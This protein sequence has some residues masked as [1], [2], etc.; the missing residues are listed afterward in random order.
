[1]VR[2]HLSEFLSKAQS[3]MHGLT[4]YAKLL[5]SNRHKTLLFHCGLAGIDLM[6]CTYLY[7]LETQSGIPCTSPCPGIHHKQ[8]GGNNRGCPRPK[9][10]LLFKCSETCEIK[11]PLS[12][13]GLFRWAT[14]PP[15]C[16]HSDTRGR[17]LVNCPV[18]S[19]AGAG[20]W[21]NAKRSRGRPN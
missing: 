13:G 10:I 2:P 20:G 16:C 14:R 17:G 12:S 7:H 3:S 19:A 9:K 8:L 21:G 5:T 18:S 11:S 4:T 1:M 15:V 6:L